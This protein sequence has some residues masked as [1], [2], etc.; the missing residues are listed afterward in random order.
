MPINNAPKLENVNSLWATP[1]TQMERLRHCSVLARDMLPG[2]QRA[3]ARSAQDGSLR[4]P[5]R[6]PG[7]ASGRLWVHRSQF[8]TNAKQLRLSS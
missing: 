5:A 2:P 3:E 1:R 7:H 4:P 6:R 8:R